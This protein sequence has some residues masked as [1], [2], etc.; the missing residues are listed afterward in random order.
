LPTDRNTLMDALICYNLLKNLDTNLLREAVREC[1]VQSLRAC[2]ADNRQQM[3]K[4]ALF[5][6]ETALACQDQIGEAAALIHMG[7]A[8]A[9]LHNFD[10][11][12]RLLGRAKRIYQRNP[13]RRHRH[14]EGITAYG[15]GLIC[16]YHGYPT[17]NLE[18]HN[19][20]AKSIGH[21]QEALD[22]FEDVKRNYAAVGDNRRFRDIQMVCNDV[23]GRIAS[24]IPQ[25]YIE[26][27]EYSISSS[28]NQDE[29]SPHLQSGADSDILPDPKA[30][31]DR[32]WEALVPQDVEQNIE[33]SN[34]Q[35]DVIGLDEGL[36]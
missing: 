4:L 35:P 19:Y 5:G 21:Y 9:Q 30:S 17:T 11:A 7:I 23:Q 15:L 12:R 13:D 31:P 6:L 10:Q 32:T 2:E 1:L 34:I 18:P 33:Q 36:T 3:L 14:N 24:L 27:T 25:A 16:E 29:T 28:A 26:A 22:L 20:R 8:Y